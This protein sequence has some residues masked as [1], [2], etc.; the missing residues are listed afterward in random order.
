[1]RAARRPAGKAV[2]IARGG[3]LFERGGDLGQGFR[4]VTAIAELLVI[5]LG[6]HTRDGPHV[7][8]AVNGAGEGDGERVVSPAQTAGILA[9]A[10]EVPE[11]AQVAERDVG[12]TPNGRPA[13]AC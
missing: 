5:N 7:E 8:H 9:H 1:M 13:A 12:K 10:V 6:H 3:G 4:E 2:L 11:M